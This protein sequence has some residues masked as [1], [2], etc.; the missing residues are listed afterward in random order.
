MLAILRMPGRSHAGALPPLTRSEA[1]LRDRLERH[2]RVLADEIGERHLGRRPA[3]EQ[4]AR[5]IETCLRDLGYEVTR[6]DYD[7][8]GQT[9]RNLEAELRGRARPSEIIIA[10]A[11]YDSVPGCPAANDNG[12]AVAALIELARSFAGRSQARTL[13]FV[14][15]ANEEP[16]YFQTELMGSRVYARRCRARAEDVRGM[17]SL[18]TIGCYSDE[19]GSQHYPFPLGLLYPDRGNFIAFVGNCASRGLVRR[20]I[21]SF[22]RHTPF[23]SEGI[24][25]PA[26]LP[27]IG[28][29]DHWS[30]WREGYRALMVTDTAPFRY[31]HYHTPQDTPEKLDYDRTARVVAGMARVFEDLV[32]PVEAS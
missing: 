22:R 11:H 32:D 6:Q 12:S 24:A 18:E 30:F 13:R 21:G 1:Q 15:F 29:S 19:P 8:G 7:A 23:P 28:W 26:I 17:I 3:L 14:A 2:V 25:A 20:A 16:P 27:G 9:A 10:G 5:Y 31:A 4:A